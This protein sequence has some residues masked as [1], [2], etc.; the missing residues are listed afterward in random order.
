MRPNRLAIAAGV[1]AVFAIPPLI[2]NYWTFVATL[3]LVYA[4]VAL[5]LVVLTGWLGQVSLAQASFMGIAGYVS[6]AVF[7]HWGWPFWLAAPVGILATVPLTVLVGLVALRLSGFHLAAATVAF[8][9]AMQRFV[10]QFDFLTGGSEGY[11]APKAS[12]FG[13]TFHS[14]LAYYLLVLVGG[15]GLAVAMRNLRVSR[16]G[17]AFLAVKTSEQASRSLAIDVTRVKLTGFVISGLIAGAGGVLYATL[18][19]RLSPTGFDVAPSIL[20]LA[21]ALVGGIEHIAGAAVGGAAYALLPEFARTVHLNG[22]WVTVILAGTVLVTV[23][24]APRGLV[25]SLTRRNG[26]HDTET[27]PQPIDLA[28]FDQLG[29]NWGAWGARRAAPTLALEQGTVRFGGVTALDHVTLEVAGGQ[30][31]GLI[32]PNG[33]GKTTCFNVLTGFV[34][35]AEGGV[36]LDR[37]ELPARPE[38]RA[39]SGIARTFQTPLLFS[40]ETVLGNL[41]IAAHHHT[42]AGLAGSLLRTRSAKR[43]EVAARREAELILRALG[44]SHLASSPVHD[45]PFGTQR[46]VE[47]ARALMVRPRILLLDEPAAGLSAEETLALGGLVRTIRDRLGA[48][49]LLIEHDV[50]LVMALAERVYVLDFG[51][52]IASGSAGDVQRDPAVR[53]AYLGVDDEPAEAAEE[54]L[55]G[56]RG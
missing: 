53:R 51:H 32:G 55:A 3:G 24:G 14:D 4:I 10:F 19:G 13:V 34:P 2:S 42:T 48:S 30:L 21:I 38:R 50:A 1:C 31:V 37:A 23:A 33:A 25:G 36:L 54:E 39:E 8:A 26:R 27:P 12:I 9:L 11:Q 16:L 18:V 44:L 49:V 15:A 22:N 5:S 35:L 17:R 28:A 20:F 45:L 40:G 52:L 41:L 29:E 7:H 47:I 43:E 46:L 6:V 56:A